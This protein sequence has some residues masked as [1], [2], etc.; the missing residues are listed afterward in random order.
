MM[1]FIEGVS[2]AITSVHAAVSLHLVIQAAGLQTLPCLCQEVV[3][4][5]IHVQ[6]ALAFLQTMIR[7][8]R[9]G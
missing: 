4:T 1:N 7:Y 3:C 9:Q 2:Q 5:Y 6:P 8:H